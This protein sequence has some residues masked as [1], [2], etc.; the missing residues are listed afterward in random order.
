[1]IHNALHYAE[2]RRTGGSRC[3]N[4]R[5]GFMLVAAMLSTVAAPCLAAPNS[6]SRPAVAFNIPSQDMESALLAFAKAASIQLIF[7]AN[8]LK[9][10]AAPAVTGTHTPSE[11]LARLLR[12]SALTYQWTGPNTVAVKHRPLLRA[13]AQRVE[14]PPPSEA[15]SADDAPVAND[16]QVADIVVTAQKREE[17]LQKVPI[18]VS[19]LGA[20]DLAARGLTDVKQ[21]Q[22]AVPGLQIPELSGIIMPF[23]RGVGASTNTLSHES[24]V[25]VYLDGVYYARLPAGM[26][27][28][29]NMAR[30]EVLKGPQG[31]LFGRNST[32]GVI[33]IVTS[34]PSHD[35]S[36]KGSVGYGRF[37][38]FQ[39]NFYATTGLSD[40]VAVDVSVS[41]KT[42]NGFGR[43]LST[44]GR[45][46]Y[47][48]QFL[49]RSKL[50]FEPSDE[51]KITLSGFY[52]W[53]HQDGNRGIFPG[54]TMRTRSTPVQIYTTNDV[55]FYDILSKTDSNAFRY[56]GVTLRAEQDLSFARFTSISAYTHAGDL[57]H[58][59][60]DRTP[61]NDYRAITQGFS[62]VLTQELQLSSLPGDRLNWVVG[63]FYYNNYAAYSK[64]QFISPLLFQASLNA[65]GFTA[66][67]HQHSLS[68]AGF[69]QATYEI[70]PKLRF[71]G[72]LRYTREKTSAAGQRYADTT[73]PTL[74]T[75]PPAA[76]NSENRLTF[77]T[78][79]DYQ[80]TDRVLFYGSFSRGF[81]SGNY[82]LLFYNSAVPTRPETLD[83]FEVGM[84]GDFF[85]KRV[86]LN[87]AAFH[88]DL[89]NPQ[90][91]LTQNSTVIFSNGG[92]A[93]MKGIEA[94]GQFV[95]FP[96]FNLRFN[97]LYLDSQYTD[98]MNAPANTLD[99]INGGVRTLPP[100]DASGNRTPYGAKFTYGIGGDYTIDT[101]NGTVTLTADYYHNSGHYFEPDNFL[102][103]NPYELLSGQI[104]Y[105]PTENLAVRFWGKN[106]TNSQYVQ[107][108]I[109]A[110]PSAFLYRPAL[111]RT[112]GV[113]VDFKF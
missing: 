34:D 90:V 104:K 113:A 51:T 54:T 81:K 112:Y 82:N 53:T 49:I 100:I 44:G 66:S 63:A 47:E 38:A 27:D 41:G 7:N 65:P 76:S 2:F 16:A 26:L 94:E 86:R 68:Y 57:S 103:Q 73:P 69:A 89:K 18:S 20:K 72:G 96:G 43:V 40:T 45:Y 67:S 80:L 14:S 31:T 29:N 36:I 10:L 48:D 79:I 85:D 74:L 97:G 109:S 70:F 98:Y 71:T 88:Y 39:A 21:L 56:W 111:P 61:R 106:L 37:D 99:L 78:S 13:I 15:G 12:S 59:D 87:L 64:M 35:T 3:R 110:G 23:L 1:M 42:N 4:S 84:K 92:G 83:A 95:V 62:R 55:G 52:S 28:L 24:S 107:L 101:G 5:F 6:T 46:G 9:G 60:L 33:N 102:R 58:I 8:E 22:V 11:A 30:V 17:S 108:G 32:G 91:Q 93:R 75:S 50:L 77:K 105:A 19:A 25:A